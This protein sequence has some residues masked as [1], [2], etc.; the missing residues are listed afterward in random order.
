MSEFAAGCDV[1][2]QT[3]AAQLLARQRI[4]KGEFCSAIHTVLAKGRGKYQN[5]FTHGP[6][7][8]GKSFILSPLKVI[9]K[10]FCKPATGSFAWIG[11]EDA[12]IIYLNEF[13]WHPKIIS[14]ADLLLALEGGTGPFACSQISL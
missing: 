5:V 4:M 7:N 12:E 6:T 9:Y 14:W 2:W 10:A 8:F 1:N 13:S 11:V 3:A